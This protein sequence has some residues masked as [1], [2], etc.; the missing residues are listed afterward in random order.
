MNFEGWQWALLLAAAFLVGLSK[1]GIAGL[2]ILFVA[3]F[4][5]LMPAKQATGV[6]LPLLILGDVFAV[7]LY[8]QHTQWSHLWK[9]FP[10]TVAGVVLGWIALKYLD[11]TQTKHLVGVIL[12]LM[13]VVHIWRKLRAGKEE[14][15]A[16]QAPLWFA[17]LTGVLAGFSTQVANA[18]GPVMVL[19]LLAMRLPKLEFLGTGAVFFLLLN[20]FKV[21]FM[22]QLGLINWDSLGLNLRLAPLVIVGALVGKLIAKRINQQAFEVTALVLTVA[23]TVKLLVF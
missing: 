19:Y 14:A 23:A 12:L 15:A 7:S 1:T 20:W 6:V 8:R 4:A 21:P 17:A 10:W 9:L 18:A 11:D 3:I 5:N 13:L 2:G 22:V 16:T